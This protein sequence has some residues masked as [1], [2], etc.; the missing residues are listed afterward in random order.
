MDFVQWL[1]FLGF[2]FFFLFIF[3][4]F[5]LASFP[6]L[7]K[8]EI[9]TVPNTNVRHTAF[10]DENL[11]LY[12]T[13]RQIFRIWVM[14]LYA[15]HVRLTT[16]LALT[17]EEDADAL[18][19]TG[20]DPDRGTGT[21]TRTVDRNRSGSRKEDEVA[22]TRAKTKGKYLIHSQND[23]YQVNE[24]VKFV[25]PFGILGLVVLVWQFVNTLLCVLGTWVFWPVSWVEEFV[26][27][28]NAQKIRGFEG[29]DERKDK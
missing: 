5:L 3:L 27:G 9:D 10:D 19:T 20:P 21:G 23:L 29:S 17:R 24:F 8:R 15:A 4:S 13:L 1:G 26:V 16:V 28:G 22:N 6:A 7:E 18:G 11:I 25:S 14:P 12:V 2:F